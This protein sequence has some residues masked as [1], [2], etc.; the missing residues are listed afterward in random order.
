MNPAEHLR[1]ATLA[2]FEGVFAIHG[3][4]EVAST[5]SGR[6]IPRE[7][8]RFLFD[9]MLATRDLFVFERDGEIIGFFRL[10]RHPARMQPTAYLGTVAITPALRGT[11]A[12][13][14]MIALA[15]EQAEQAGY[16][17]MEL[18]VNSTNPRA[19]AFY[20]AQGFEIIARRPREIEA[21]PASD[22]EWTMRRVLRALNPR[23]DSPQA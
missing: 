21:S 10:S 14:R 23:T 2:D 13:R 11:G 3:H 7:S 22:E 4:P 5:L 1:P 20:R 6:A 18:L 16:E 19:F 15:I 12:A 17:A 8:F 9:D